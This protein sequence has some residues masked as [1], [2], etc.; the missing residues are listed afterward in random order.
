MQMQDMKRKVLE[1][2]YILHV[3]NSLGTSLVSIFLVI[4]VSSDRPEG[5]CLYTLSLLPISEVV[6]PSALYTVSSP[7]ANLHMAD[8]KDV[9]MLGQRLA[10]RVFGHAP[11]QWTTMV[12][13][14]AD[15]KKKRRMTYLNTLALWQTDPW[16]L[17]A[18]DEDVAL[19]GSEGVV[20]GVLDV[21]DVEATVVSLSVSD[22][23]DST[24]VATT[25]N[26][27]DHTSVESDEV[28]DLAGCKIDLDGVVDLDGWVWVS[29]SKHPS[30]FAILIFPT[31]H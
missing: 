12:R 9:S 7:Q 22:D 17:L 5:H 2:E 23:T 16:L 26:H 1:I 24:H 28:S 18:D 30:A 20:D 31:K 25:S 11:Q 8:I 3:T 27:S 29:D 21:D 15:Q 13:L 6:A 4:K 19:S 14:D 10:L